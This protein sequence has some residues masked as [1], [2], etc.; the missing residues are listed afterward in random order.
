[1]IAIKIKIWVCLLV[2]SVSE[3]LSCEKPSYGS[4]VIPNLIE[5]EVNQ[6]DHPKFFHIS[7]PYRVKGLVLNTASLQ[8]GCVDD[9]NAFSFIPLALRR[10][11]KFMKTEVFMNYSE[12]KDWKVHVTY[13][14]ERKEE[15]PIVLDGPA[16][17]SWQVLKHNKNKN[18]KA[19]EAGPDALDA[20][21]F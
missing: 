13:L 5:I 19:S 7:I 2:F 17:E 8:H 12:P 6:N 9:K 10:D 18:V 21:P 11:G 1:M 4:K 3:A 14:T 20:R 15:A 16:I